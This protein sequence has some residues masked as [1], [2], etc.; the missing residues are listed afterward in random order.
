MQ[1][2]GNP[3]EGAVVHLIQR[4]RTKSGNLNTICGNGSWHIN[5]TSLRTLVNCPECLKKM[6]E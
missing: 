5:Y 1:T 3:N 4:Q 2:R 6:S